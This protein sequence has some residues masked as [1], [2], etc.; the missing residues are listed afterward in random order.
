MIIDFSELFIL[1]YII[2]KH[3]H[4]KSFMITISPSYLFI[5][6]KWTFVGLCAAFWSIFLRKKLLLDYPCKSHDHD[7]QWSDLVLAWLLSEKRKCE[8]PF[9]AIT[10]APGHENGYNGLW[11]GCM[12]GFPRTNLGIISLV[13]I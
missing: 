4:S 13:S 3:C 2:W 6:K 1:N 12:T 7:H 10:S 11:Y 9:H 8:H 5:W